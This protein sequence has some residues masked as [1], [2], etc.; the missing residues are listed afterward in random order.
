MHRTSPRGFT[1]VELLVVI[2]IIALLISIL[3]PSLNRARAAANSIDCQSRLRQMGQAMQIY[4]V[5]N[6]GVLPY[7]QID[8]GALYTE[9]GI[10]GGHNEQWWKWMYTL[11]EA[12]GTDPIDASGWVNRMSPLFIDKDTIDVK[13]WGWQSH[14]T[15]N[16][17]VFV[18][19]AD[20]DEAPFNLGDGAIIPPGQ[21]PPKRIGQIDNASEVMAIWDGPQGANQGNNALEVAIGMDK[22]MYQWGHC[23]YRPVPRS[24]WIN[25]DRPIQPGA[26]DAQDNPTAEYARSLQ[27]RHNR[28]ESDIW[29]FHSHLRF[30]HLQNTSLNALF[31]DGHVE[32][33][34]VGEVMVRDVT[35]T[36]RR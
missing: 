33:R 18:P 23:F 15:A 30:R 9:P 16:P 27:K 17:R 2:G 26:L 25:S 35:V 14:Y 10:P 34:K 3:L 29:T 21:V 5:T 1:L 28:D 22:W 6:K 8:H 32:G 13:V 31:V 11:T 36:F 4:T 12:L 20:R 24:A 19:G 7:S